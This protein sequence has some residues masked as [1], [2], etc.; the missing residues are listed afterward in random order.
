VIGI[1]CTE[2]KP[3]GYGA[4]IR[5]L[6]DAFIDDGILLGERIPRRVTFSE[7]VSAGAVS[8]ADFITGTPGSEI[9]RLVRLD[10]VP[11]TAIGPK[12]EMVTY[13]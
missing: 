5:C 2:L 6:Q 8:V 12:I 1:N 10:T 7:L 3:D 11:I 9:G 4:Q 13:S